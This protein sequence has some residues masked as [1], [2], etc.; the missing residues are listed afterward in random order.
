MTVTPKL[1]PGYVPAGHTCSSAQLGR[2]G[3]IVGDR[4][5]DKTWAAHPD[6]T[7][8]GEGPV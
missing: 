2:A 3:F 7:D 1:L 6:H 8:V 4:N 5:G